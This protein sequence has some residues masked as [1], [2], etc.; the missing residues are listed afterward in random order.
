MDTP[1]LQRNIKELESQVSPYSKN[2]TSV[3]FFSFENIFFSSKTYIAIPIVV[4]VI[5]LVLRPGFLYHEKATSKGIVSRSL[6]F[7][8]IF[9]YWLV[10]SFLLIV[11]F[12][13]YNYTKKD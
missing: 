2:K 8:R 7:Q 12:F 11:G 4:L 13:G 10:I 1:Q 3:T 9:V 6:S 5:L